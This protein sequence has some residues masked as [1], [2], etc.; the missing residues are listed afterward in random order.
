MWLV[1]IPCHLLYKTPSPQ[2]CALLER[3]QRMGQHLVPLL[4]LLLS[5]SSLCVPVTEAK[6]PERNPRGDGRRQQQKGNERKNWQKQNNNKSAAHLIGVSHTTDRRLKWEA[7][8]DLAFTR[9]QVEYKE[10][11]LVVKHG[12]LYYVYC[13]VG[14]QGK[15]ANV[16]LSNKVV[17]WHDSYPEETVL[18]AGTESVLRPLPRTNTNWYTSL[19]QGGLANLEGGHRLYVNVSHPLLVDYREGKTVFGLVKVS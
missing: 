17:T 2:T 4:M 5:I 1:G 3:G 12:G 8:H 16:T 14:F 19:S 9:H 13:Q 15:V 11:E 10:P 7:I 18:L 6:R